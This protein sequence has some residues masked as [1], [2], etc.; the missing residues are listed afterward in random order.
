MSSYFLEHLLDSYQGKR[1]FALNDN[2]VKIELKDV[3]LIS[4]L[5][6]IK[7]DFN[8]PEEPDPTFRDRFFS[9]IKKT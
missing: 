4:G 9:T 5:K 7:A 1:M 3:S 6:G 8:L 2:E